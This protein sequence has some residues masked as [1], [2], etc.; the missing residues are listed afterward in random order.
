MEHRMKYRVNVA[1]LMNGKWV[2]APQPEVL[3]LAQMMACDEE[4]REM[5]LKALQ[6]FMEQAFH[7]D[8]SAAEFKEW[9]GDVD[10]FGGVSDGVQVAR[11]ETYARH[12]QFFAPEGAGAGNDGQ[13]DR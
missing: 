5:H 6:E 2:D 4:E 7:A 10:A 8:A 1:L 12:A 13:G 11:A 3:S 9:F